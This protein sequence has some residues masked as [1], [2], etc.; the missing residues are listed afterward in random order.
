M[1]TGF[2]LNTLIEI[3]EDD[4]AIK[5]YDVTLQRQYVKEWLEGLIDG[6][7]RLSR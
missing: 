3:S 7:Q 2:V 5:L 1:G 6:I 4:I